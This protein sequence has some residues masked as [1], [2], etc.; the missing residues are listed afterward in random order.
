MQIPLCLI[1]D[2]LKDWKPKLNLSPDEITRVCI[3]DVRVVYPG[4]KSFDPGIIYILQKAS[5]LPDNAECTFISL[6]SDNS[7]PSLQDSINVITMKYPHSPEQLCAMISDEIR[8]LNTWNNT[9]DEAI[10]NGCSLQEIVDLSEDFIGNP[11]ILFGSTFN[12][13]A[14]SK[15]ITEDDLFFYDVHHNRQPSSETIRALTEHNKTRTLS[16]GKFVSGLSYRIGKG[17]TKEDELFTDIKEGGSIMLGV[18]VR[19]SRTPMTDALIAIIGIFASKLQLYYKIGN[20]PENNT[21][22]IS[23]NEYMFPRLLQDNPEAVEL[24]KSF[25]SFQDYYMIITSKAH[26]L[27]AISKSITDTLPNSCA[28]S[29]EQNYYIFIPTV[30]FDKSSP[31]YI[32]K[33]EEYLSMLGETFAIDIGISG[34]V[35][36]Y[37]WL[38]TACRQAVRAIDLHTLNLSESHYPSLMLYKDITLIDMIVNHMEACPLS[39]FAPLEYIAMHNND[40]VSN[41][42]YCDFFKTYLLNGCNATKTAQQLFLHKNSVIYRVE[43]IKERYGVSIDN[44]YDQFLFLIACIAEDTSNTENTNEEENEPL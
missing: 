29:H 25:P 20:T 8:R 17:P 6:H 19:F 16:Y 32:H 26:T 30:L 44:I 41:T 28:F 1:L 12:C 13:L 18:T 37:E 40:L 36:G 7:V 35:R 42:D 31:S 23:L 39:S 15:N 24:A 33:C 3:D 34:P 38:K 43:K 22:H 14:S 11:C 21:G 2:C 9:L 10:V 27:R 4:Q 5:V